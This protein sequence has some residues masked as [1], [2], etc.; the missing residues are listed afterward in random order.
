MRYLLLTCLSGNTQRDELNLKIFSQVAAA[1]DNFW[2]LIYHNVDERVHNYRKRF[3]M[4]EFGLLA[5]VPP[6][7]PLV[8]FLAREDLTSVTL[9]SEN[10]LHKTDDLFAIVNQMELTSAAGIVYQA[11]EINSSRFPSFQRS[12]HLFQ[13]NV[14]P[15]L[16]L[17]F[18]T[19][20]SVS[21]ENWRRQ[22]NDLNPGQASLLKKSFGKKL[23]RPSISMIASLLQ[24]ESHYL[25]FATLDDEVRFFRAGTTMLQ[26]LSLSFQIKQPVRSITPELLAFPVSQL[27]LWLGLV[28]GIFVHPYFL[29]LLVPGYATLLPLLYRMRHRRP[30]IISF[31]AV[32]FA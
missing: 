31:F 19:A 16:P 20:F 2:F 27:S 24:I 6:V 29:A 3:P 9:L 28:L 23:C 25:P 14:S 13:S 5:S 7:N 30:G 10:Y 12:V 18:S 26:Q 11:G 17:P 1:N 8:E 21:L 32:L 22:R 15:Y 4:L